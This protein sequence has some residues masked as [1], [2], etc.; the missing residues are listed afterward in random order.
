MMESSTFLSLR[1]EDGSSTGKGYPDNVRGALYGVLARLYDHELTPEFA[2]ELH[3]IGFFRMLAEVNSSFKAA[4]NFPSLDYELLSTEFARLFIGP[5]PHVP[6][7]A[8]VHREDDDRSGELWGSTTGEVKRFMEHYGLKLT[9]P[10]IIPDHISVLLEFMERLILARSETSENE[11]LEACKEADKIQRLFFRSY[12][13]P[14]IDN[15]FQR[16]ERM[17]PQIFYA[18]VLSL[19]KQFMEQEK[20]VMAEAD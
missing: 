14:W 13:A 12:V 16:V 5:G 8:S 10:G 4:E 3:R 11:K 18:S 6:P 1:P 17:K 7:Y 15:F 2:D 20:E 9:K 19:T